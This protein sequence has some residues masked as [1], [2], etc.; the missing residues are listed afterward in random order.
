MVETDI[1]SVEVRTD[2]ALLDTM[3]TG[4]LMDSME[5][6]EVEGVTVH[7][8]TDSGGK[9][10]NHDRVVIQPDLKRFTVLDGSGGAGASQA[11]GEQILLHDDL[12]EAVTEGRQAIK[13]HDLSTLISAT[14]IDGN[15]VEVVQ[16]GDAG[17]LVFTRNGEC[18]FKATEDVRWD[19]W[20]VDITPAEYTERTVQTSMGTRS[21]KSLSSTSANLT[22][23]EPVQ[24]GSGDYVILFSDVIWSNFSIPELERIFK[25][26]NSAE[27]AFMAIANQLAKK[28]NDGWDLE[29]MK[30]KYDCDF[31]PD[32]DNQSLICFQV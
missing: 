23:Y 14:L 31:I 8:A 29:S 15:S 24:L 7:A 9:S 17:A 21:T 25:D 6:F 18:K 20:R 3:G 1:D 12:N 27:E 16:C 32:Q 13:H 26:S 30:A 11:Y 2:S 22:K 19:S 4:N 28:F 10:E 5:T